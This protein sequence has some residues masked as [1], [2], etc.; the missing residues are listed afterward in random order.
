MKTA[1][2]SKIRFRSLNFELERHTVGN[3]LED[4]LLNYDEV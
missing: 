4:N 2:I 3:D 1:H